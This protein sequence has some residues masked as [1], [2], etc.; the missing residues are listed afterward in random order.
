VTSKEE[1]HAINKIGLPHFVVV[2]GS[3]P[4]TPNFSF[5][6]LMLTRVGVA[7]LRGFL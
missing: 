4:Q 7:L 2:P 5:V 6:P 3:S 1:E